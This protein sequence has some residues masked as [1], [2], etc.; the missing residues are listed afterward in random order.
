MG[1]LIQVASIATRVW[2][3]Y[4]QGKDIEQQT[5]DE[6]AI[7]EYNASIKD[8]EA[9]LELQ[10]SR[11]EAERFRKEGEAFKGEQAV[12]Y[13]K[14]GVLI[15][16]TPGIVKRSTADELNADRM[17]ILAEGFLRRSTRQQ[18]AEGLRYA[19]RA[20]RARGYNIRKRHTYRAYG[21]ILTGIG[22]LAAG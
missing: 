2:S 3:Q 6:Q 22:T 11:G 1:Q 16:G 12:A 13:A 14:G 5:K 7:L 10:R 20:T 21:S 17:S 18:E 8:K 4:Q 15:K 19:G 9:E